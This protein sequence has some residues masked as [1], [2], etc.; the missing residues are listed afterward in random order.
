MA[1][2]DC[3]I[4]GHENVCVPWVGEMPST[5]LLVDI[6]N[7]MTLTYEDSMVSRVQRSFGGQVK[8]PVMLIS[9]CGSVMSGRAQPSSATLIFFRLWQ[10]LLK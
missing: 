2:L 5:L 7:G 10:Y 3:I 9:H 6:W 8:H 4:V 1:A